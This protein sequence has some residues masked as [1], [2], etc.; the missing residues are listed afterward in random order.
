MK[1]LLVWIRTHTHL[2]GSAVLTSLDAHTLGSGSVR[3]CIPASF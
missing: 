3:A 1:H 2:A